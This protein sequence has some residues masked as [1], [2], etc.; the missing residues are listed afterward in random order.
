MLIVK[1]NISYLKK[2]CV[3]SIWLIGEKM[4]VGI[5]MGFK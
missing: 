1:Y 3:M 5:L 4:Q 2:S